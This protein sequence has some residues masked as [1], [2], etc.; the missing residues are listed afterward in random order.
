[1]GE[2]PTGALSGR[3]YNPLP[4]PS[5]TSSIHLAS[6]ITAARE[7]AGLCRSLLARLPRPVLALAQPPSSVAAGIHIGWAVPSRCFLH[8]DSSCLGFDPFP[9]CCLCREGKS[10]PAAWGRARWESLPDPRVAAAAGGSGGGCSQG[11]PR[12]PCSRDKAGG[13]CVS[14]ATHPSPRAS[15]SSST[16]GQEWV[17][18]R[19]RFCLCQLPEDVCLASSTICRRAPCSAPSS[20]RSPGDFRFPQLRKLPQRGFTGA[21]F[22]P[23]SPF[24]RGS[25]ARAGGCPACSGS[26][27][28]SARPPAGWGLG[29][30][31]GAGHGYFRCCHPGCDLGCLLFFSPPP[32]PPPL[33]HSV[34]PSPPQAIKNSAS[35]VKFLTL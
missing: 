29:R 13:P 8:L 3:F 22:P 1:M 28:G 18:A 19:G 17:Q 24:P 11:L 30:A 31:A 9:C 26:A 33:A 2:S 25:A 5:A 4:V 10:C 35:G 14:A 7:E 23:P 34:F 16:D 32:P 15:R 6:R 12:G 20:P 27:C 21:A